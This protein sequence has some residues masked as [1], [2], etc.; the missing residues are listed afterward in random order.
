MPL[1]HL[2]YTASGRTMT[3]FT[4]VL[5]VSFHVHYELLKLFNGLNITFQYNIW[6]RFSKP[7]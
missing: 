4:L 3:Y 2:D 1:S 7:K 6:I 5:G